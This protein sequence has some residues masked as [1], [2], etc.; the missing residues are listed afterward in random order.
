MNGPKYENG[1]DSDDSG[2]SDPKDYSNCKYGASEFQ[3]NPAAA[4]I[5]D[6]NKAFPETDD[7]EAPEKM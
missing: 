1:N 7:F 2:W 6:Q 5:T 4:E 3:Y